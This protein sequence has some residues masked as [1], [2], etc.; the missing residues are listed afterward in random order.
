MLPGQSRTTL[1]MRHLHPRPLLSRR[2]HE[3]PGVNNGGGPICFQVEPPSCVGEQSAICTQHPAVAPT[4]TLARGVNGVMAFSVAQR[5]EPS[6]QLPIE[7]LSTP[8]FHPA[9]RDLGRTPVEVLLLIP[10]ATD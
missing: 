8:E 2:V 5:K 10:R 4:A 6:L 3:G 1:L 9:T 7:P